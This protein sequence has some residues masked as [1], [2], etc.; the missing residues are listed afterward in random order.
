[1]PGE[2]KK[3][4]ETNMFSGL[5]A[6]LRPAKV[7]AP[8]GTIIRLNHLIRPTYPDWVDPEWINAANFVALERAGPETF[9]LEEIRANL[10]L[11]EGQKNGGGVRGNIIYDFLREHDM[12][13]KHLGLA[14][15]L[16]I[17]REGI[18]VF[19]KFFGDKVLYLW[20]GTVRDRH[21][22]LRVPCLCED[23]GRVVLGW[24][25]LDGGWRDSGPAGRFAS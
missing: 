12:L 23:G 19:R 13:E 11:H 2:R 25:W 1:M 21:G 16:A 17:Q 7:S 6:R 9:T 14:D 8:V 5:M 24:R 22:R 18:A 10:W 20:R 4:K 15:G 3:E